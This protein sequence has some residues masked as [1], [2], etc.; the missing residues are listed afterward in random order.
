MPSRRR[1]LAGCG[2]SLAGLLAGGTLLADRSAT[3]DTDWPMARYDAAGT[4]YNPDA[5]GPRDEVHVAW[6]ESLESV[7]GF[8]VTPPVLVDDTLYTV[9]DEFVAIDTERGAARFSVDAIDA[10]SP[11]YVPSSVYQT[12]TL[13]VTAKDGV[14]GLSAGGG[15]EL[16]GLRFGDVRWRGPGQVSEIDFRDR[17]ETPS[18]VRV[19]DTV[20]TAIPDTA[21]IVALEA[22]SGHERWRRGF[23]RDDD[24]A[25]GIT[26]RPAVRDG[27]VF[28]TGRPGEVAAFDAESGT[29]RWDRTLEDATVR[30]PTATEAGVVVPTRTG[31]RL[32][33]AD[34][35]ARRWRK[36]LE[37]NATRG[38]A[39]VAEGRVFVADDGVDGELHALDLETGK[40]A[41]SVS[42]GHDDTPIVADGV[43]YVTNSS[44]EL[45]AFD[46]ETGDPG[47]TYGAKWAISMPA[48][49]DGTLYV[50]DGDRVLALEEQD[51]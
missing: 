44:Y 6:D 34:S 32:L 2:L 14:I 7:S 21:E 45:A 12:G 37:G 5:S 46:A 1:L 18:P 36:S 30:P 27:I 10:S 51:D 49:G 24:E 43:V 9:G 20:Y 28:A 48:V 40:P 38:A 19:G 33:E 8:E 13:A 31:I 42:Y 47:C 25:G 3:T 11:T 50:V 16:F 4:G 29:K 26:H 41:W 35:G 39:A 17:S 15:V 22:D 23:D